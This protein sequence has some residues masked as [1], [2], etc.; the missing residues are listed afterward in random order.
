M[1]DS[2][3]PKQVN[4]NDLRNAKFGGG[5]INADTVNAG[6]I[7]G[8][9]NIY[10]YCNDQP[11][12][13]VQIDWHQVSSS[14]LDEHLRLTTNPLT[15]GEGI[16]YRTEQVY[17]PLGLVERK[18][19]PRRKEDVSPEKGSELYH[20]TEI[21]QT[22]EHQQFLEQV[23]RDRQSPRSQGRRIAIIGEPGA[24]KTTLLQQIAQWV[25]QEI[26]QSVVIWVSLA[27]LR[28]QELETYLLEVWLK[29][30]ARTAGQAEASNQVKDDFVAQ[31][32]RGATRF[33]E[34]GQKRCDR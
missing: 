10:N 5:L 7:G 22:F 14:L 8:D 1:P 13:K 12:V 28:S 32:N 2:Q 21:T 3:D 4:N 25:S 34:V 24:G 31:F 15:F 20:E 23:L 19:Q 29:A 26:E 27:D 30:V 11:R 9:I 33:C 17:V 18:K 16:T 6:R